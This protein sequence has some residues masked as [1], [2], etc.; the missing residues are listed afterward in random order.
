MPTPARRIG[1]REARARFGDLIQSVKEGA[2]WIITDRG[3]PV[4]KLGGLDSEQ[5]SLDDRLR[6]MEQSGR[7]AAANQDPSRLAPPLPLSGISVQDLLQS[8]R[9]P[10]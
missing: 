9:G 4:A 3:R 5:L 2:E 1:I 10:G 7:I 6:Q 8:E